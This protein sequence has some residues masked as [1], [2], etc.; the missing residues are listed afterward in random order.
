MLHPPPQ[1]L[2]AAILGAYTH[3]GLSSTEHSRDFFQLNM[4]RIEL[5]VICSEEEYIIVPNQCPVQ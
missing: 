1:A 2:I 3:F 5:Q 4:H